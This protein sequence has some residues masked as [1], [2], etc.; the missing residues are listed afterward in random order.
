MENFKTYNEFKDQYNSLKSDNASIGEIDMFFAEQKAGLENEIIESMV[1]I[2][3]LP[4]SYS[5]LITPNSNY[6]LEPIA[7]ELA[8]YVMKY[9]PYANK[10]TEKNIDPKNKDKKIISPT[11]VLETLYNVYKHESNIVGKRTLG[12]G[13]IEN[14]FNVIFNTLGAYMPNEYKH[15]V[16]KT[17]EDRTAHLFLRHHKMKVDGKDHISLSNIL[18]VDNEHKVADILAQLINGWV[19]VEKDPWIFFIQGNYETAPT[20]MYLLKTGVPVKEAIYFVSNPL[21]VE[22]IKEK[23]LAKSTYAEVLGKKADYPSAVSSEAASR[24]IAKYF[25]RNE[26]ASKAKSKVIYDTG[27]ELA[28]EY[29]SDRKEQAFTEREM[30]SLIENFSKNNGKLTAE[31]GDLAKA[32]FLHFLEIEQQITGLTALKLSSNPDTS[33]KTTGSEIELSEAAIDELSN[34]TKIPKELLTKMLN[35]SIISSFFN[36]PMSLAVIRPLFKLRYNKYIS[37]YIIENSQ[38]FRKTSN[39][40]LGER[41]IDTFITMFRNDIIS[42]IFQNAIRKYK[43]KDSYMSYTIKKEIPTALASELKSRGAFVKANKDGTKFMYI[44][45]QTLKEEFESEAWVRGSEEDNSYENRNMYSLDPRTFM[46]NG[47]LN[48]EL[49]TRFVVEREFLRSE[50]PIT[51]MVNK[52]WFRKEGLDLY[53]A[54]PDVD[55]GTLGR[56]IYER[57]IT[58]K[59]LDNVYNFYHLFIDKDNALASRYNNFLVDHKDNLLNSYDILNVLKLD[60]DK[61]KTV[62]NVYLADKDMNTDKANVYTQNLRNLADRSVMKVADKDENDRISDMFALMSNFAFLQTGL[63]KSKLS[64]TN[65]VDFTNFLDVMKSESES[66][67][68]A[69]ALDGNNILDQFFEKFVSV[70]SRKNINKGRFKDYLMDID[71]ET[72]KNVIPDTQS[73]ERKTYSGKVTSLQPNQIFVFG[74]NPLGINGNPSKGTGGAAL[75]AYRIAGVKQ[76]E[77]MDNRLSDSGKA[78]GITT[79]TGPGK[80]KS[81]TPQEIIEGVKKLYEYAKENPTKE[82]LVSDYSGTNLNGYTG[83]EMA[84]MFNAA[85]PIPSNIVFNENF[86]KYI[87]QPTE[88]RIAQP[89]E[90]EDT[91]FELKETDRTNVFQ[92]QDQLGDKDFYKK[93]V[94]ANQTVVFVRNNVNETYSNK[95]KNFGGQQE[96]D[97]FAGNMTMNITTSLTKLGDNFQNLPKQAYAEVM[98]LWEEEIAHIQSINDGQTKFTPI[99]FPET[100]FGDPALMP[101]ELFV[102][103]STRLFDAFGYVNPGSAMYNEMQKRTEIAEGLTDQEILDQLGLEEDPFKCE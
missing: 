5:S 22:Y 52:S 4:E 32:M 20:L 56:F 18:D 61:T 103:L 6:I 70:N 95:K 100:G 46:E 102:Y 67:T 40:L 12:L 97:K 78:W 60:S 64:Y 92:Y 39:K 77:K 58:N 85:G 50:Y 30:L 9:N 25:D 28:E 2:L 84:D 91:P 89:T 29:L 68:T 45:E 99:A 62:F 7:A 17:V 86:D 48:F 94:D 51:E 42:M 23:T 34:E 59:A 3:E 44:D 69:L 79:V 96:L 53:E 80:K 73:T 33:T 43:I 82:F 16:G 57:Y 76:G 10:M 93:L 37:D 47:K 101:Q 72:F 14:T 83:Q 49:Y 19:D 13:A 71:F 15:I 24:I 8:Q 21:V 87:T 31:E 75:V 63:N 26:L 55:G 98:R 36:G 41:K 54:N 66:F 65:V 90:T 74:S 81:K 38:I 88:T 35:D 11:R 27:V 1:S